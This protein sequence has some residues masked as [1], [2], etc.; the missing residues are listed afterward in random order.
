MSPVAVPDSL[1]PDEIVAASIAI[2]QYVA[3]MTDAKA[4]KFLTM[5]LIPPPKKVVLAHLGIPTSPDTKPET[6]TPIIR[7][8]EADVDIVEK[9]P[10]EVHP[11]I[12]AEE[13]IE[14]ERIV[15][16][17]SV[18]QKL[19]ADVGIAPHQI[20][21]DGWSIGYDERFPQQRR[22]LQALVYARFSEH[23]HLYAHPLDFMPILDANTEEVIQIDFPPMYK[24]TIDGPVLS[25]SSTAPSERGDADIALAASGRKRIP[26]P[27]K[28]QNFLPDLMLEDDKDYKFRDDLKPLH[29]VQPEGVSFKINGHELEWQNW[30]MHVSFTQREGIALSTI[31]YNDHGEIR[32]IIYRLSVAEMVVPY[33]APEHPHPRKFAFDAGEYGMGAM[34]NELSLGCDCLGQIH[35]LPGAFVAH[36][37]TATIIKN[38]ICIHEEDAGVLWKH[39]DYRPNGRSHTVQYIWNYHFYQDGS[40]ECEIRLTGVLNVYVAGE[41]EPSPY[42]TIVSPGINAQSHQHLFSIRVDPMID[43]LQNSVIESDIVPLPD[44]PTG[45]TANFSGNAFIVKD[46]VLS[47]E[48]GRPYSYETERRWKIVNTGRQH[49][50]SG[51]NVGYSIGMKGGATPLMA[52][53]DSWAAKR[54]SFV[55]KA[56]WVLR[57]VEGPKGGRIWPAGNYVPQ[58]RSE[59]EDS[60][61]SWAKGGKKVEDED[62]VV[63]VTVG[64]MPVEHLSVTLKPNS[65]FK[66]NPS[67]D[68]PGTFDA[69]SVAA[70]AN[71]NDEATRS[72]HSNGESENSCHWYCG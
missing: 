59:P 60:V 61:G 33:G 39:A 34:A 31:T 12:S 21:C 67:M 53:P 30:K 48:V 9:L 66:E 15:R 51:K 35:Y 49:F 29:V 58:T 17:S 37:G 54:A 36:N 41:N 6:P 16:N 56:L 47:T 65:F 8:A 4:I 19:A 1:T 57:D 43:G 2:R 44:A 70:F 68:V 20:Y 50:A 72:P 25:V 11:Q 10:Q 71:A 22:I 23:D 64:G 18:V 42:G 38:A 69:H 55:T 5:S 45:S 28:N 3:E 27:L 62:I 24:S 40:I 13:L 63:F 14:A 46:T 26:P 7:Q 32:P 52:R